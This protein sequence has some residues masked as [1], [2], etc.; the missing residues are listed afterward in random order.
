MG[1]ILVGNY[2]D[3]Y[4][5]GFYDLP[6]GPVSA[7]L[8]IISIGKKIEINYP[9]STSNTVYGIWYNGGSSYTICGGYSNDA[10]QITDVYTENGPKPIG[11][12]YIVNYDIETNLF[13]NWTSINYPYDKNKVSHFQGIS[14]SSS[15]TYQLCADSVNIGDINNIG[16]WTNV[17]A[18]I[19]GNF[20]V[21]KWIDI[22][23]PLPLTITSSNSV[24]GNIIVGTFFNKDDGTEAFQSKI[25][26]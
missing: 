6:F 13:S 15:N 24:S 1:N 17:S 25:N 18:D 16:S 2:D 8:Y 14:K 26:F 21:D 22:K 19:S 11:N 4:K 9:G 7:F 12:A 23:Y 5:Y 10:I 3:I 20:C